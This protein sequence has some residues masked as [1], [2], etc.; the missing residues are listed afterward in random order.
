[1]TKPWLTWNHDLIAYY[2]ATRNQFAKLRREASCTQHDYEFIYTI[3]SNGY[4]CKKCHKF[5]ENVTR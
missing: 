5:I 3:E 1:M 4:Q 2:Y